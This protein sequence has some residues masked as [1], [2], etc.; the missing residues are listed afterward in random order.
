MGGDGS[1]GTIL[2]RD[3]SVS[4]LVQSRDMGDHRENYSEIIETEEIKWS[5]KIGKYKDD[6]VYVLDSMGNNFQEK[7]FKSVMDKKNDD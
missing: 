1:L 5:D 4:N 2:L 6:N 7:L 3:N